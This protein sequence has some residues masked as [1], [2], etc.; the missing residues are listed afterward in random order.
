M[1]TIVYSILG[2]LVLIHSLLPFDQYIRTK[3]S[4]DNKFKIWWKKHVIDIDSNE[5]NERGDRGTY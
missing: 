4:D 1:M 5:Q 3:V 2:I